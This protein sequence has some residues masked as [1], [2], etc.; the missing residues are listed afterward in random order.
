M[1][2]APQEPVGVVTSMVKGGVTWLTWPDQLPDGT[3]LYAAPVE[4]NAP[5]DWWHD[6]KRLGRST[7]VPLGRSCG[8]CGAEEK[9]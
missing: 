6:C 7:P 4:T 3:K 1:T 5:T 2:T 9:A 8:Y